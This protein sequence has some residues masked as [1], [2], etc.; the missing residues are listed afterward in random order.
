MKRLFLVH[1]T[2]LR[3]EIRA[4]EIAT[5]RVKIFPKFQPHRSINRWGKILHFSLKKILP[6][7]KLL[8]SIYLF[9]FF[10]KNFK[11]L[12]Y[13][14]ESKFFKESFRKSLLLLFS[15]YGVWFLWGDSE[16]T[17]KSEK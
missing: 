3:R 14:A 10:P 8:I 2:A 1:L 15:F 17:S 6:I 9:I 5:K 13:L 11:L 4:Q 16:G 7:L 12:E